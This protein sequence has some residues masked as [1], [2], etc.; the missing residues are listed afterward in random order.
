MTWM[1][2]LKLLHRSWTPPPPKKNF[3]WGIQLSWYYNENY[4]VFE[5]IYI[6]F[7]VRRKLISQARRW[8]VKN[9]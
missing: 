2:L 4:N 3:L 1:H 8:S 9:T 5:Y 6:N 7:Y